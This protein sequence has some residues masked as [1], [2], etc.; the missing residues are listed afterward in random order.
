MSYFCKIRTTVHAARELARD[1]LARAQ[2]DVVAKH[3]CTLHVATKLGMKCGCPEEELKLLRSRSG[4]GMQEQET[5]RSVFLHLME[6]RIFAQAPA[7]VS[8]VHTATAGCRLCSTAGVCR[9]IHI[10]QEAVGTCG[11]SCQ[12]PRFLDFLA[13]KSIEVGDEILGRTLFNDVT[14]LLPQIHGLEC[15]K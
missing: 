4:K 10:W 14:D 15:S 1:V 5:R 2:D 13:K 8:D 6:N 3:R 11:L 9:S 12:L 7:W